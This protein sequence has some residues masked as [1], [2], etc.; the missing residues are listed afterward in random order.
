MS[1]LKEGNE[2]RLIA[3]D[4]TKAKTVLT[5]E[6]LSALPDWAPA[7]RMAL[8]SR[9]AEAARVAAQAAAAERDRAFQSLMNRAPSQPEDPRLERIR[10]LVSMNAKEAIPDLIRLLSDPSTEVRESAVRAL[11]DLGS[12][13]SEALEALETLAKQDIPP[14]MRSEVKSALEILKRH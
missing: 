8:E 10:Q 9:A 1:V 14:S 3:F 6:L 7:Q 13:S 4:G 5:P 2:I 12:G 11:G